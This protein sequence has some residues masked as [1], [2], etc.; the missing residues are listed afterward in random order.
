MDF[1][2]AMC[3]D[4]GMDDYIS[5]PFSKA[6]LREML[7]RWADWR[8]PREAKQPAARPL[9]PDA[10]REL[11]EL[12]AMGE[13][14]LV[15]SV[16]DAYLASSARLERAL[17]EAARSHDAEALARAAHPLKSSSAQVGA[18]RLAGLCKELESLGRA[19][20][21]ADAAARVDAVCEEL[22]RVREMLAAERLGAGRD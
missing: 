4:A 6:D 21:I 15:S 22:E 12:E 20:D 19:G 11:R 16:I 18:D 9:V 2:R 1:D 8:P 5:K 3:L 13:A 7:V 17:V 10:L 14:H